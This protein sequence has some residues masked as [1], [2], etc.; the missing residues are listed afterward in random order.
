MPYVC[1][2]IMPRH[3]KLEALQ[4]AFHGK[5]L[6]LPASRTRKKQSFSRNWLCKMKNQILSRRYIDKVDLVK[7]LRRLFGSNYHLEVSSL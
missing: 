3:L 6:N 7:L 2:L 1:Q 5:L 4:G